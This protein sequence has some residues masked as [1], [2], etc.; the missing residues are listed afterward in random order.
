MNR[1]DLLEHIIIGRQDGD[2]LD[3]I[4]VMSILREELPDAMDRAWV[5]V[6]VFPG[7]ISTEE[8]LRH[9]WPDDIV[10]AASR[11]ESALLEAQADT[12]QEG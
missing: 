9:H 3:P 6:Q 2:L 10:A 7:V 11:A 12:G 1:E 4:E 5:L 8:A